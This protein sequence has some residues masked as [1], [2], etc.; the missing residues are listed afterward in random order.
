MHVIRSLE[1]FNTIRQPIVVAI[2]VFDGIHLGHQQVIRLCREQAERDH[3]APWVM[4]FEPHPLK[5]VQ[6]ATAPLLLTS[7]PA[8]LEL[9]EQQHASGCIV[10]PFTKAFSEIEPETFLDQLVSRIPDL[11]GLVIGE[12]W[13]FGRQARGNVALLHELSKK[14]KFRVTVAKPVVANG[15][16]IS[17]SRIREA[18]AGGLLDS[19]ASMLGRPHTVCG[20]VIHGLKRG[21]RLGFP[22]ANLDV[23]GCAVPPPGIYAA[24]VKLD[25]R[26]YKGALY[27]PAYPEPHHG[28]LEVHLIDF[29]GDL[30]NRELQVEFIR[31]IRNDDQRFSNESDLI[32]QIR[33]DVA[34]IREVVS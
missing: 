7:L 3:A 6:P 30:Y 8:K 31:K 1:Q 17:S 29:E 14:Y 19:A 26:E 4:T 10:T 15:Q 18:I 13:R 22:T 23:Q 24:R 25:G 20:P 27:L 12:N 5:V 21:R 9:L 2:G 34:V 33:T 11:K 28:S 16:T 32:N